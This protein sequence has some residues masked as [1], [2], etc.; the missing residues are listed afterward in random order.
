MSG[1]DLVGG[2]PGAVTAAKGVLERA[3][4]L[5]G[6]DMPVEVA[7]HRPTQYA[8]DAWVAAA[9][10]GRAAEYAELEVSVVDVELLELT[11]GD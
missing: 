4:R 10:G 7:V 2:K 6:L 3:A 8:L 9:S 5:L 11:A 1:I